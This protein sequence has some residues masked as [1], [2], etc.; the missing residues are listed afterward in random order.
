MFSQ[1]EADDERRPDMLV[2]NPQGG[3]PQVVVEVAV[4]NFDSSNR[5]NNNK[6]F[7]LQP[8]N[9]KQEN[10]EKQLKKIIFAYAQP[11]FLQLVKWVR[12]SKNS[13]SNKS[14]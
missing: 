5:S 13:S 2:R 12:V 10:T 1:I 4:S 9:K 14:D 3:G 11:P 6:K 8:R 7:L